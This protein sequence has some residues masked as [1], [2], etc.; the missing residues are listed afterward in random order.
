MADVKIICRVEKPGSTYEAYDIATNVEYTHDIPDNR[1]VEA[2]KKG[3]LL[4]KVTSGKKPY[5]KMI[6]PAT[7]TDDIKKANGT[8]MSVEDLKKL[9]EGIFDSDDHAGIR[10]FIANSKKLKPRTLILDEILWKYLIRQGVRG[11]NIMIM[12]HQGCGKTMCAHA[13]KAALKRPFHYFNLGATQ[14]PRSTLIGNTHSRDGSTVFIQSRFARAIQ[15]PYSVILLDEV[16][17]A[18]PEAWNILMTVVDPNQRYLALD[19]S[20]DCAVIHVAEGV[21]FIATANVGGE[22][23]STRVMDAAFEDRW[24]KF[25]MPLLNKKQEE[26]RLL[27]E[28]PNLNANIISAIAETCEYTRKEIKKEDPAVGSIIST[29][30]SLEWGG[31]CF[32][33]FSFREGARMAVYSD[34][35][36]EG[37]ADSERAKI[38]QQIQKWTDMRDVPLADDEDDDDDDGDLFDL[39]SDDV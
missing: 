23:T 4:Q 8:K 3:Y 7:C 28:Y 25:E 32:D 21:T 6:D 33:G 24:T 5:W 13:L 39:S 14:D 15:Q 34:F 38:K 18:H 2:F 1:K 16:S 9:Y 36:E 27:L 20:E 22:F 12:G 31:L 11:K 29:R 17:R 19:E 26:Q 30:M 35:T 37:G 10:K